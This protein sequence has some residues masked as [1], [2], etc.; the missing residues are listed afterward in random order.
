VF[1]LELV[2]ARKPERIEEGVMDSLLND[3]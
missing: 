3:L 2:N 1:Y